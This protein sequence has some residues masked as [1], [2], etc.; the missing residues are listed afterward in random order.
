MERAGSKF[1]LAKTFHLLGSA[2]PPILSGR[3][4]FKMASMYIVFTA[5]TWRSLSLSFSLAS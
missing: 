5:F 2:R 1:E 4:W 3:W